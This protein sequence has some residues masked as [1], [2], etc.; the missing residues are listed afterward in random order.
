MNA[1]AVRRLLANE[2]LDCVVAAEDEAALVLALRSIVDRLA[3]RE[4]FFEAGDSE[5]ERI[6]RLAATFLDARPVPDVTEARLRHARGDWRERARAAEALIRSGAWTSPRLLGSL[7]PSLSRTMLRGHDGADAAVASAVIIALREAIV[8]GFEE[9]EEGLRRDDGVSVWKKKWHALLGHV[10]GNSRAHGATREG[11]ALNALATTAILEGE[12][13]CANDAH[14]ALAL[15][16]GAAASHLVRPEAAAASKDT[17]AL[18]A[19]VDAL[20]EQNGVRLGFWDGYAIEDVRHLGAAA[21]A[22]AMGR[23]RVSELKSNSLRS[24]TVAFRLPERWH[25]RFS[26][27]AASDAAEVLERQASDPRAAEAERLMAEALAETLRAHPNG[28]AVSF[29]EA[30]GIEASELRT[31]TIRDGESLYRAVPRRRHPMSVIC[32]GKRGR[33]LRCRAVANADGALVG[34]RAFDPLSRELGARPL[35]ALYTLD[36]RRY[37]YAWAEQQTIAYP[38]APKQGFA[39]AP[40]MIEF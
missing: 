32:Y 21:A 19:L 25:E 1:E 9:Q 37:G 6:A 15:G 29:A 13:L 8:P 23:G 4:H 35:Y 16:L 18:S 36:G 2:D 27:V 39:S 31:N 5:R 33:A 14:R 22:A 34:Y 3:D 38:G 28:E 12:A 26:H 11:A 30:L 17:Q 7:A 20:A 24:A 10:A 40:E